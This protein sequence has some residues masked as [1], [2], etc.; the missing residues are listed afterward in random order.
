MTLGD[1]PSIIFFLIVAGVVVFVIMAS[2]LI[3]SFS[4]LK[5]GEKVMVI[6]GGIGIIITIVYA[7]LQLIYNILI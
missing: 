1:I 2:Y 4:S 5:T 7:V 3:G 6:M